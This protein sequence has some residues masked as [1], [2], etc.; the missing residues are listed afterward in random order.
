[1]QMEQ[2]AQRFSLGERALEG[3]LASASKETL[4]PGSPE[5]AKEV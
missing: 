2:Y 1:M 5:A 4:H 3:A